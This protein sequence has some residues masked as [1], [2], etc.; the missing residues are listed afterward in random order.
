[1]SKSMLKRIWPCCFP[2]D[3]STHSGGERA[4]KDGARKPSAQTKTAS[5]SGGLD[6]KSSL[7]QGDRAGTNGI[8]Q[9]WTNSKRSDDATEA[10]PNREPKAILEAIRQAEEVVSVVNHH[11]TVIYKLLFFCLYGIPWS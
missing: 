8:S 10:L 9:L 1:M 7:G 4:S 11:E 2:S 5:T 3:L 6:G